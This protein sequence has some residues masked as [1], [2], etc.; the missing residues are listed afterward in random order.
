ML[1]VLSFYLF[2][3]VEFE[4]W[5]L[6]TYDVHGDVEVWNFNGVQILITQSVKD[7]STIVIEKVYEL[8][9]TVLYLYLIIQPII[10]NN[11]SFVG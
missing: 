7:N 3:K 8:S 11:L 2:D 4:L 10:L 6:G 9:F 5:F 1:Y